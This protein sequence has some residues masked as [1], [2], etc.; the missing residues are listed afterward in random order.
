MQSMF[1]SIILLGLPR[2]KEKWGKEGDV[3]NVE[4][5]KNGKIAKHVNDAYT[6]KS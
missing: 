1:G 5:E 2:C 4:D 6:Q 3:K